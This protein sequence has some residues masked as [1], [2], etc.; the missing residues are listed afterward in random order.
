MLLNLVNTNRAHHVL[1]NAV[2]LGSFVTVAKLL[3]ILPVARAREV[4]AVF[5]TV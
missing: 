1:D 5:R 3:T 2:E 4:S